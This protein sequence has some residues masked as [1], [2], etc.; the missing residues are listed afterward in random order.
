MNRP[1]KVKT[2]QMQRIYPWKRAP[3]RFTDLKFG[4]TAPDGVQIPESVDLEPIMPPCWDQCQSGS[5]TGHGVSGALVSS[6]HY[7]GK[8]FVMPSRLFIYFNERVIEG[9]T[10]TDAGA[11]IHDGLSA[12]HKF[13][14]CQETDWP[15]DL[16]QLTVQPSPLAYAA[17]KDNEI[18]HYANMDGAPIESFKLTL[19]HGRG[20]VFG[21]DVYTAFESD[22]VAQTGILHKPTPDE[23]LLGGHCVMLAGYDDSKNAF[24]VRN[25][26]GTGWGLNG[27]YYMDYDYVFSSMASDFWVIKL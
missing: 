5:C 24:K 19:A 23:K 26:W 12:L 20:I 9:D 3:K 21:F 1:S 25:S 10:S 27:Y 2:K 16:S 22:E 8:P 14:Y 4:M 7:A 11:F 13:G 18:S 17:A 15:F 6:M